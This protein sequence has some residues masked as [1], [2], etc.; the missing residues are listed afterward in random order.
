VSILCVCIV[1]VVAVSFDELNLEAHASCS[2]DSVSLY[3]G[4]TNNSTS[5]GKYC[6]TADTTITSSGSTLFVVFFTDGSVNTGR[7]ALNWK[8]ISQGW[9]VSDFCC[10]IA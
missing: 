10:P 6:T 7:F 1:K 3:D 2:Y 8:F 9:F 4:H 5:L